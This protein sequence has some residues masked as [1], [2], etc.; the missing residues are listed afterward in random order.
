MPSKGT[1][2]T[3]EKDHLL[4]VLA[5]CGGN[6]KLAIRQLQGAIEDGQEVRV[7]GSVT[8]YE[9]LKRKNLDRYVRLQQEY[10][11]EIEAIA[12]VQ[13]RDTAIRAGELEAEILTK[14]G[15][16]I[17]DIDAKSLA[18]ALKNVAT[19]KGINVDKLLILTSRPTQ[20][21][22]KRDVDSILKAIAKK[23]PG[24]ILMDGEAEEVPEL[25]AGSPPR[26]DSS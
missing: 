20:I 19:T 7:P 24:L 1:Y 6:Y 23:A 13:A 12:V 5:Y 18:I 21:T 26:T 9:Q 16:K 22:D 14:I 25:E 3:I 8:A 11:E 10:A 15:E 17:D 2:S 4:L